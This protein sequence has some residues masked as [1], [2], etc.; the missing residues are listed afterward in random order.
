MASNFT[1]GAPTKAEAS[2]MLTEAMTRRSFAF[3]AVEVPDHQT[4]FPLMRQPGCEVNGTK[5]S[6]AVASGL[7]CLRS[8]AGL[9]QRWHYPRVDGTRP[10]DMLRKEM[11]KDHCVVYCMLPTPEERTNQ[12]PNAKGEKPT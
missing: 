9:A 11:A 6:T 12:A 7:N 10:L 1:K 4:D 2:A 5:F 8:H 3:D